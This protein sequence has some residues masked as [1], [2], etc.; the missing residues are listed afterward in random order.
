MSPLTQ[1]SVI[2]KPRSKDIA[3][4]YS[5]TLLPSYAHIISLPF[6]LTCFIPSTLLPFTTLCY[7][8]L[9]TLLPFTILC[10]FFL[11]ANY[12]HLWRSV[13]AVSRA[14]AIIHCVEAVN[15]PSQGHFKAMFQNRAVNLLCNTLV[16]AVFQNK[17]VN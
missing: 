11:S 8:V 9:T 5:L 13:T 12:K 10:F 2:S 4:V 16:E 1:P 3:V 17:A 14:K 15:P 6:P 7:A